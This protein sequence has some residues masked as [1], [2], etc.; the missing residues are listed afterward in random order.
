M[1]RI[2]LLIFY[3][4]ITNSSVMFVTDEYFVPLH[5]FI[6]MI[7]A[8]THTNQHITLSVNVDVQ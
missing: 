1:F 4:C 5:G 3:E 7:R 8:H 6:N 2:E